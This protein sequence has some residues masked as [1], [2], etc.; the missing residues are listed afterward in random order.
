VE[1]R[2]KATRR[3][4]LGERERGAAAVEL[5][6]IL[7]IILTLVLGTIAIGTAYF[8]KLNLTEG[9]REGARVGA[10]L[11]DGISNTTFA[12]TQAWLEEVAT[13][14]T[15]TAG[16]WET[17]CVSYTGRIAF[18]PTGATT[19]RSLLRTNLGGGVV[20]DSDPGGRCFADGRPE[21]E[22][23]VQV[24]MTNTGPFDNFFFMRS[25]LNLESKAL[26]RFERPYTAGDL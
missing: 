26:A 2:S 6:V 9:A 19:T 16:R 13:V 7:P 23:R 14:A 11:R 25:T 17:V 4:T 12:P 24:V 1:P 21:N 22:R 10:T 20:A 15:A 5:I 3:A 18:R 8:A